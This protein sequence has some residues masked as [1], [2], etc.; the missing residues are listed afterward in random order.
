MCP[1]W[2]KAI[3]SLHIPNKLGHN[4]NELWWFNTV[5][6][7]W[8]P[9]GDLWR[10]YEFKRTPDSAKQGLSNCVPGN[11]KIPQKLIWDPFVRRLAIAGKF[12]WNAAC[13]LFAN[14]LLHD[15]VSIVICGSFSFSGA[16][17]GPP[18]WPMSQLNWNGTLERS[19][20][21]WV[22]FS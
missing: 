12:L 10:S 19:I 11:S 4:S 9:E 3:P 20:H 1:Y 15:A 2:G 8:A 17:W 14:P 5:A 7:L 18:A 21:W 22:G 16:T 13:L 6:V